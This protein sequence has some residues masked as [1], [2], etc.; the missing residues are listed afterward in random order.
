VLSAVVRQGFTPRPD[1]YLRDHRPMEPI[2][3]ELFLDA[4]PGP[5]QVIGH[6]LRELVREAVPDAAERVRPGWHLIG[7]DAPRREA[8]GRGRSAY[9]A[10]IAPER[11][12]IHLGFEHGHLMRD[13]QRRL[14]G[15]GIT[16]QV[17]WLTFGPGDDPDPSIA[18]PLLR[19]ARRVA[20]LSRAERFEAAMLS[21]SPAP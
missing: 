1:R 16:R 12:H 7:Y 17:R 8:E 9:F 6:R 5:I 3:P 19:E 11:Q 13:P 15:E 18:V 4:F 14:D 10:Y 20:L 21:A 2:P